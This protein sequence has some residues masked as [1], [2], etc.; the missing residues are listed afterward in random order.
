MKHARQ[1]RERK[2]WGMDTDRKVWYR[3]TKAKRKWE[4]DGVMRQTGRGRKRQVVVSHGERGVSSSD[5]NRRYTFFPIY[6]LLSL[7][8]ILLNHIFRNLMKITTSVCFSELWFI[9]EILRL[10]VND[11]FI[12]LNA[13]C[14]IHSFKFLFLICYLHA[15]LLLSQF[16][17]PLPHCPYSLVSMHVAL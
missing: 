3:E 13:A 16:L 15:F 2:Y 10:W 5:S 14:L 4:T 6:S 17:L 9:W 8:L 1:R 11:Y 12:E 7:C